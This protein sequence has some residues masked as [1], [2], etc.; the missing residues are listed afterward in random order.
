M[1]KWSYKKLENTKNVYLLEFKSPLRLEYFQNPY[2]LF[3]YPSY[4][5]MFYLSRKNV[6]SPSP[7]YMIF[8]YSY[9]CC[10]Y[11]NN[12]SQ[13]SLAGF[14]KFL[15]PVL[16]FLS[17]FWVSSYLRFHLLCVC[18][19]TFIESPKS[20]LTKY[21]VPFD[22]SRCFLHWPSL[23]SLHSGLINWAFICLSY[24]WMYCF[25]TSF[26]RKIRILFTCRYF[27]GMCSWTVLVN[28][29]FL[30][31]QVFLG[32]AFTRKRN[33]SCCIVKRT[34]TPIFHPS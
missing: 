19:Y 26:N 30:G 27:Q 5:L 2:I 21:Q 3:S 29:D 13:S 33:N 18:H 10:I 8:C 24:F 22:H 11:G 16:K 17:S 34:Y 12:F 14:F 31:L 4:T 9:D 15:L 23:S 7:A 25:L 6:F 20:L 32:F 1:S 28:I